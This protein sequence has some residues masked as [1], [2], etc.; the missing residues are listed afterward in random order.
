MQ[1][2]LHFLSYHNAI[3]IAIS[4]L[5]VGG[6]AT[7]AATN[8]EVIY[9][10]EESV[11]SIDNTYIAN[12][13]LS[14]YTPRV[15]IVGVTEDADNYYIAYR[16]NTVDIVDSVWQDVIEDKTLQVAKAVLGEY[17]DLGLYATE[18]LKQ[19]VDRELAYLR[20]V[21]EFERKAVTQKVVATAYSGL[22][23]KLLDDT[24]ETIPGYVPVVT[25]PPI[26]MEVASGEGPAS[27]GEVAGVSTTASGPG[28]P[29]IQLLGP[30]PHEIP[31]NSNYAD[32]GVV[33]TDDSGYIPTVKRFVD[34]KEILT[35]LLTV[36]TSELREW[37]IRYE[38]TDNDGN[39][40]AAERVVKVVDPFAPV[41]QPEAATTTPDATSPTETLP[42]EGE[43]TSE[44]LEQSIPDAE[45]ML[46]PEEEVIESTA[47]TTP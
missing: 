2:L 17:G 6:S 15:E 38:A 29:I 19:V 10:E 3:P 14:A 30:N 8:P 24:T 37:H 13:D 27:S 42:D 40:S 31:L 23:G 41:P 26:V 22:V 18:Q 35:D 7:F 32:L 39:V 34:G 28:S 46:Q 47:T 4:V 43:E 9:Q 1:R 5:F 21:Q 16:F 33:V 36:D 20:E 12:K 45:P 11:V 44:E 25:P